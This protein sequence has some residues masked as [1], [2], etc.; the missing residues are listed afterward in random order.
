MKQRLQLREVPMS[1]DHLS[2]YLNDHL[3]GAQ[4]GLEV[5]SALRK[6]DDSKVWSDIEKEIAAD[7]DELEQLV[8]TIGSAPSN[9][10]RATAWA[11]EKLTE[12]KV[13][14]DDRSTTG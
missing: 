1:Y 11:T 9:F 3:A 14:V 10:R 7:R 13:H 2:V 4:M 8:R 6:I 12:L 5:L